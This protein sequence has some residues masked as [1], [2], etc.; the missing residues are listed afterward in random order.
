MKK[1]TKEMLKVL[2]VDI[3]PDEKIE[4]L[5]GAEK[6]MVEISK[7]LAFKSRILIMDEPTSVLTINEIKI[8]FRLMKKLQ[9]EG[10]TIIYISHKLKEV[11]E[12]CDRVMILRDGYFIT[13]KK[14]DKITLR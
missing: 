12:I 4:N 2:E 1:K 9:K 13:E 11:K 10:L 8:L 14:I 5:S 3:S 6:Q 7:A